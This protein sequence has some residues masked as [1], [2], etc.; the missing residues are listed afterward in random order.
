MEALA[1]AFHSLRHSSISYPKGLLSF[2]EAFSVFF[3]RLVVQTSRNV[4]PYEYDVVT[5]CYFA[6]IQKSWVDHQATHSH[7]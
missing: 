5:V 4:V 1:F 2:H 3:L 6:G 7:A